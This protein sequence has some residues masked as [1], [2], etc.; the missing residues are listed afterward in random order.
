MASIMQASLDPLYI[1]HLSQSHVIVRIV[2]LGG[3]M[4]GTE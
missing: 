1:T 2:Q 4:L 3:L